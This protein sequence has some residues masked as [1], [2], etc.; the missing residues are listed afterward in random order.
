MIRKRIGVLAGQIEEN[1]QNLF[2]QGFLSSAFAEDYDVC[3]FSMY[4][5][6]QE[7]PL[8]EIGDTNIF[9]LINYD[10]LDAIVVLLDTLQTPGIAD[11]I[12]KKIH[13]SFH[14]PVLVIDK[15]S[16]YFP[17]LMIDHCTPMQKLVDHLIEVHHYKDIIFLN[18][19]K[20]HIH[21]AQRLKGYMD[22][23][24]AHG[25]TVTDDMIYYG[26]YWYDSGDYMV[27]I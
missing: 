5:K 21:S 8:R 15:E 7:T 13:D 2:L 27:D 11:Y 1:T 26:T 22:S 10:R 19:R 17:N 24:K 16:K 12:E 25:L 3:I 4:Q 9:Q 18:G 14:G 20:E 23:M 6:Y